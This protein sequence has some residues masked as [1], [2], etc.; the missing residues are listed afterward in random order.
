MVLMYL[1]LGYIVIGGVDVVIKKRA[2]RLF[3]FTKAVCIDS[4]IRNLTMVFF[5]FL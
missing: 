2:H 5:Q 1:I 3:F 4:N